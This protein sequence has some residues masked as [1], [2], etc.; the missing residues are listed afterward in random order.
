MW[1]PIRG[2]S[3]R[4]DIWWH[5]REEQ[6]IIRLLGKLRRKLTQQEINLAL[7]QGSQLSEL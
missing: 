4:F 3:N 5:H 6:A 1:V 7:E 2:L